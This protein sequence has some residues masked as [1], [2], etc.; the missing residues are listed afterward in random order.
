LTLFLGLPALAQ[1]RA[2]AERVPSPARDAGTYHV[3]TRTWSRHGAASAISPDAV[4]RNDAPSG[5][6]GTGWESCW[7]VDE[8]L[9]PGS[10]HPGGG[11]ASDRYLVD[12]LRFSYCK[13]GSGTV[14]WTFG[15]YD[16][17]T[18]C[19]NG[20]CSNELPQIY[21]VTGL[22]GGGLCW[23]VT[24][25]LSGGYETCME[26][27]GGACAPGYQGAGLAL[28]LGAIGFAWETTDNGL[29]GPL[30]AGD[31]RWK[32]EGEGTCFEP[33][34]TSCA[35]D[36]TGLGFRDLFAISNHNG[37]PCAVG[38]GC[39]WFGGYRAGAACGAPTRVPPGQFDLV[40]YADC[41]G[42]CDEAGTIYC[43]ETQNPKNT[44]DIHISTTDASAPVIDLFLTGAEDNQPAYALVGDG[45]GVLDDPPGTKGSLCIAGGACL[46][47]YAQDMVLTSGGQAHLDLKSALSRP[48]G[49]AVQ[50]VP[51]ATWS[52]QYWHR[53]PMGNPARFSS[54]I[55]VTFR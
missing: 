32:P 14:D 50:I 27:D 8:I 43:Y 47:R 18:S 25:D 1:Q 6:W 53:Q 22:P 28:D 29:C 11:S 35:P 39:Y 4:Y 24:L 42:G 21:E 19:F 20:D 41:A 23:T 54:A 46:G 34:F 52:F 44:A 33:G 12:G 2:H 15:A 10:T 31:P 55:R 48:C 26:A 40:L 30:L 36:A 13:Q 3:A 17:Y 37:F 45:T 38:N 51:G 5:Y 7:T 49:G 16:S 9:L